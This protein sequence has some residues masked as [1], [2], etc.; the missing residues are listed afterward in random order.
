ME[1]EEF[2]GKKMGNDDINEMQDMCL[3]R[4]GFALE[5]IRLAVQVCVPSA[6]SYS[7]V[8][9]CTHDCITGAR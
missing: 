1:I 4:V 2:V 8:N 7:C 9:M 3:D 5:D 6:L